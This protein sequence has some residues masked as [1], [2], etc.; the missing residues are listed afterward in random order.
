MIDII[1]LLMMIINVNKYDL[2]GLHNI[3]GVQK[4]SE[5]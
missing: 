3:L 4:S 2:L 1:D 5:L